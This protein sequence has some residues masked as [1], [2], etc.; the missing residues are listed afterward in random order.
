MDVVP[1]RPGLHRYVVEISTRFT[2]NRRLV[3]QMFRRS[4]RGGV[5]A[6]RFLVGQDARQA[7]IPVFDR[8]IRVAR[9]ARRKPE[10][11]EQ[12]SYTRTATIAWYVRAPPKPP[13]PGY[14]CSVRFC[15]RPVLVQP[16]YGDGKADCFA[17]GGG[18]TRLDTGDLTAAPTSAPHLK[19]LGL[20]EAIAGHFMT[21]NRRR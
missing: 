10:P 13:R 16:Q 17:C 1:F 7:L 3:P 12:F 5:A 9:A 14:T 19:L 2:I 4:A 8:G 15:R 21:G 18:G 6:G 11:F 20:G